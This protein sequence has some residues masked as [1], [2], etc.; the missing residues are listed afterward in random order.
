M[1]EC[2]CGTRKSSISVVEVRSG[3][4]RV[5][6]RPRVRLGRVKCVRCVLLDYDRLVSSSSAGKF[7]RVAQSARH[8]T[9]RRIAWKLPL[10]CAACMGRG[11]GPKGREGGRAGRA[12]A[13]RAGGIAL[14]CNVKSTC[15]RCH[16][17]VLF[18]FEKA[19]ESESQLCL[20]NSQNSFLFACFVVHMCYCW[21]AALYSLEY[22]CASFFFAN[23]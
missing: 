6:G 23:F 16:W 1:E 3:V 21:K 9:S 20:G 7:S 2:T 22:F 13:G 15:K 8:E 17:Y 19:T 11:R 5:R 10:Q 4:V 18:S 14:R 12:V